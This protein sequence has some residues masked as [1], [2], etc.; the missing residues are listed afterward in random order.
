MR[1][2]LRSPKRATRSEHHS[3]KQNALGRSLYH[4]RLGCEL[5]EDRRL[6][7]TTYLSDLTW[8]GIGAQ[9]NGVY[10]TSDLPR[11]G[12]DDL[13]FPTPNV[14][15][16]GWDKYAIP[17]FAS[18][19]SRPAVDHI[20]FPWSIS[21][22]YV[23][24]PQNWAGGDFVGLWNDPSTGV[25]KDSTWNGWGNAQRYAG[26]GNASST[27]VLYHSSS[28]A[29]SRTF[30]WDTSQAA[31][32]VYYNQGTNVYVGYRENPEGVGG[33]V[34][35]DTSVM[36]INTQSIPLYY[37][38]KPTELNSDKSS[39]TVGDTAWLLFTADKS[40]TNHIGFRLQM[41]KDPAFPNDGRT[42]SWLMIG[43]MFDFAAS[44]GREGHWYWRVQARNTEI[45][46]T[47]KYGYDW[48]TSDWSSIA[49]FD[50]VAAGTTTSVT[51]SANPSGYG[52]AITFTATVTPSTSGIGTPTGNVTFFDNGQNRGAQSLDASGKAYWKTSGLSTGSHTITATYSGSST[53]GASTGTRSQRVSQTFLVW[54]TWGGH[55]WFAEKDDILEWNP[56]GTIASASPGPD[57]MYDYNMCWA[58]A[59]SNVLAWT[60][61][62]DVT[63][64]GGGDANTIFDYFE[65]HWTNDGGWANNAWR[66]WADGNYH[67]GSAQIS[68]PGG[69]FFSGTDIGQYIEKEYYLNGDN[70]WKSTAQFA[71]QDL[72]Q[73][74][75]NA[76]KGVVVDII[77]PGN[78]DPNSSNA[79]SITCWGFDYDTSNPN[80]YTGIWVSDSNDRI[81]GQTEEVHRYAITMSGT[82]WQIAD[83]TYDDWDIYSL[84]A[85]AQISP[86]KPSCDSPGSGA[87]VATLT[88]TLQ[89]SGYLDPGGKPQVAA[90][91]QVANDPNFS[92]LVW[93]DTKTSGAMTSDVV[94][95]GMLSYDRTYYWRVRYKDARAWGAWSNASS[96]ATVMA[97]P[98]NLTA[99]ALSASQIVVAWQNNSQPEGG[100][101]IE[102]KTGAGDSWAQL[103]IVGPDLT[104]YPDWTASINTTYYYRV[105]AFYGSSQS[106]FSNEAQV[107]SPTTTVLGS[108]GDLVW[109]DFDGNG[110]QDPGE[111]GIAGAAIE[112]F[113]AIASGDYSLAV[114]VTDAAGHYSLN[115]LAPGVNYYLAFRPPVGYTF[116]AQEV[117]SDPTVDSDADESGITDCFS[118][119]P[120]QNDTSHDAGLAGAAPGFGFALMQTYYEWYGA[121]GKAIACD[122]TGN[123]YTAASLG[124]HLSS[125]AEYSSVGALVWTQNVRAHVNAV[126]VAADGSICAVGNFSGTVDFDP[127][128]AMFSLTA[129]GSEGGDSVFVLKLSPGGR[130]MWAASLGRC[131]ASAT[132]S[133]AQNGIAVA[134]DGS[135]YTTGYTKGGD[136]DPGAAVFELAAGVFISKLDSRGEFVWAANLDYGSEKFGIAVVNDGSVCVTGDGFIAKYTS[137]GDVV[138]AQDVEA[139]GAIAVANDGSVYVTGDGFIAKYNGAGDMVWD[140]GAGANVDAI[141]VT[142]DGN[143][144]V[145]G[146]GVVTKYTCAGDVVWTQDIEL[147]AVAIAVATDESIYTVG[148]FLDRVDFDPGPGTFTLPPPNDSFA[149]F[150]WK[151]NPTVVPSNLEATVISSTQIVLGWEND[152][153][154]QDGLIIDRRLGASGAWVELATTGPDETAYVDSMVSPD[155]TYYYRVKAF[156]GSIQSAY[157]N[158]AQVTTPTTPSLGSVGDLVWDDLNG[159]GLQDPGEPGIAGAVVELFASIGS[160]DYSLGVAL[161]D[162]AGHYSFNDLAPGVNYYLAFRPP[163]GYTFTA[164][165][166]GNDPTVDSDADESGITDSFS[167]TPAQNDM[168]HDAGLA[169]AAPG[170]G[171]ALSLPRTFGLAVTCDAAGNI[172][173]VTGDSVA[174]YTSAGAL[175]WANRRGDDGWTYPTGIALAADGSVYTT[176][177]FWR[178]V[179]FDPGLGTFNLVTAEGQEKAFVSKLDSDGNFTWARAIGGGDNGWAEGY[180]IAVAANGSVCTTGRFQG[181]VDFDP[182]PATYNLDN[183]GETDSFVL[184][185][186]S[187]GNFV[188]ARAT[189]RA[190]NGANNNW[191]DPCGIAVAADGSVYTTGYFEGTVDF[192]PGP[193]TFNLTTAGEDA[194]ILRLDSAG[195]FVSAGAIG[196][197]VFARASGIAVA[198]DGSVYTTGYFSGTVDFDPGPEIFNL[199]SARKDV[200]VSR[201]DSAGNLVW[202]RAMGGGDYGVAKAFGIAVAADGSVYTTGYFWGI[203]DFD[204]GPDT[205]NLVTADRQGQEDGFVSKLDSAGN[206]MWVRAIGGGDNSWADAFVIAA[207]ADG[208]VYT[209]GS[210]SGTVDFDPGPSTFNLTCDDIGLFFW[211]IASTSLS[212]ELG[213]NAMI[214]EGSLLTRELSFAD[215]DASDLWTAT[216]DYGEG[217]GPQPLSL[218]PDKSFA[219][220]H[221]Y[222]DNGTFDL[223]V[224]I[225]DCYGE[226]ATDSIVVTADNVAPQVAAGEDATI[227]G[228]SVFSAVGS[229][230]DPGADTWTATVDY[231][232]GTGP[233]PLSLNL[234]KTFALQHSYAKKG[235]YTVT[236][237]VTDDDGGRG[238]DTLVVTVRN[239]PPVTTNDTCTTNEDSVLRVPAPGVLFNDSDADG[240]TLTAELVT[241]PSHGALAFNKTTGLFSYKPSTNYFGTDTFTYKVYDGVAWSNVAIV[242]IT[243]NPINDAPIANNDAY[244]MDQNPAGNAVLSIAAPGLVVNDTDVDSSSLSA[245]WVSNP[246]QGTLLLNADGSFTY[247]PTT[248]YVGTDSFTY[249]ANDGQADSNVATVTI[250]VN[251][252]A[253]APPTVESVVIND[254]SA[255]RS[256]VTSIIVM[257]NTVVTIDD[258]AAAF[259]MV[260]KAGGSPVGLIPSLND[261]GGKT[262]VTLAFNGSA[263]VGGSLE[264]GDYLLKV[265]ADRVHA[266]GLNLDG[267]GDGTPND[268]FTYGAA[269][270]D[271]F[272]R[273]FGDQD[274]DRDVDA[275]DRFAFLSARGKTRGQ[276]GYLWYFD[277]DNDGDV[278]AVGTDLDQFNLRYGKKLAFS[279]V[280]PGGWRGPASLRPSR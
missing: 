201:L 146:G 158:E 228:G 115:D 243:V 66:W 225:A 111:P 22:V 77:E 8:G 168:C 104:A 165:A 183:T 244:T 209:I 36:Q 79:H 69:N 128:P 239:S 6:L 126:A 205:F 230:A 99:T 174:K 119:T 186:D 277:Y 260:N 147:D 28:S 143:V 172:Y 38:G 27:T 118:L 254:G 55:A 229:F 107:T 70:S 219:L 123:V 59:A 204:P 148:A 163:V 78:G 193:E 236:V 121:F 215:A 252:P 88:P 280:P 127:G 138:W 14:T 132:W 216:V 157:S 257:F 133:V 94:A 161:T 153:Y 91:F 129:A 267:N 256:M 48:A 180:G 71:M 242:T 63:N 51:S 16:R 246:T 116:T 170:F 64:M 235:S 156:C 227:D 212:V 262:V 253:G 274:G 58:A 226:V 196:G 270:A 43:N 62:G 258:L 73:Y 169:G 17:S 181:T 213:S 32:I 49:S 34:G 159:D 222:T 11:A 101:I 271:K 203:V 54:Q 197:G 278:D 154:R 255:Q 238:S 182:G 4:R 190:T 251:P 231:G 179:D 195:N 232:D 81:G 97:A 105:K 224:V 21:P 175:I 29:T 26:I 125:I 214:A 164:R 117:G 264:D 5:L 135:I 220:S 57:G 247:T 206:F 10:I 137:A 90:E 124:L 194:F 151:W 61:W 53:F 47:T 177:Y 208:S 150:L 103:A 84:E 7:S 89:G 144:Y 191:S 108:V 223:T 218:N 31:K 87:T 85:L 76:G 167:L 45:D 83:Q 33:T 198:A 152:D 93:D 202:A 120:A 139:N 30:T 68:S 98:S 166:V 192:D 122:A 72:N 42:L 155:T 221:A 131:N 184:E 3:N 210:F 40:A 12:F 41:S 96:F 140:Q 80:Y 145:T 234:D 37:T 134:G 160:G 86:E 275:T 188:W 142:S 35:D 25:T 19:G 24:E 141:A 185:L 100:F 67:S 269:A 261:V 237:T 95:G 211:K 249:K 241:G 82:H 200:Y 259:Q 130:F 233:K 102:R 276:A 23:N 248:G 199:T 56:D 13:Q 273:L 250:T 207:G 52:Q 44:P 265:Y 189:S 149:F 15:Y 39:Y 74:L 136:F 173:A 240:D 263:V 1:R 112:L 279:P 268:N 50:V 162:V 106:A 110:L 171:F 178:T 75:N 18:L 217:S 20:D 65:Q 46:A 176:G 2:S 92:S 60:G 109:N 9:S 114:A 187:E 272:F 266:S 245:V 113:A